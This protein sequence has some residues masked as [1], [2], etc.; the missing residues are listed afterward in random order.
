MRFRARKFKERP[1]LSSIVIVAAVADEASS[2]DAFG[3]FCSN[4]E[5]LYIIQSTNFEGLLI[6]TKGKLLKEP[7]RMATTFWYHPKQRYDE[8]KA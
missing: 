3:G 4:R 6:Y 8:A 2:I 7:A 5:Y 1:I